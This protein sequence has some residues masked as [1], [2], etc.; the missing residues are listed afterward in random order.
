M[1]MA[2]RGALY[3]ESIGE[4]EVARYLDDRIVQFIEGDQVKRII[5]ARRNNVFQ[6]VRAAIELL[7]QIKDMQR[8][9][10]GDQWAASRDA[11]L[12]VYHPKALGGPHIAERLG[13]PAFSAPPCASRSA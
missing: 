3:L 10:L 11:E 4:Q 8:T 9:M 2:G 1:S 7:P 5:G 12:L 6:W 13:I